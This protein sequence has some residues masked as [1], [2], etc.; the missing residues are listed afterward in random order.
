M[1]ELDRNEPHAGTNPY[2]DPG[3]AP[4]AATT[5]SPPQAA[6]PGDPINLFLHKLF[7]TS[8]LPPKAAAASSPLPAAA[9]V[10]QLLSAAA[11]SPRRAA[12]AGAHR[13]PIEFTATAGEYFRIWIV[14]LALTVL[15]LGI[16]SAWA[17]VRKKRYFYAHT[18]ID[19]DSFEY[20]GN[21][22]AILKGR[23]IAVGA[24][25]LF[26]ATGH[27]APAYQ[28]LLY[29][30]APFILPWLIV[31]S[32]AFN[33][34][35]TAYRN[36][37]LHFRGG[38]GECLGIL[39]GYGLL[40]V[41]TL[42]FAYPYFKARLVKF[43]AMYHDYGSVPF[44]IADIRNQFR[45]VYWGVI[46]R[47]LLAGVLIGFFHAALSRLPGREIATTLVTYAIYLWIFAYS[48]V[49][50]I[51]GTF[52]NLMLG[53]VDF[54]CNLRIGELFRLYLGNIVAII[55]TLGLATPWAVVRTLRY[56]A[57][58]I[59]VLGELDSFVAAESAQVSATGE[60]VGE[61]FGIDI[62]L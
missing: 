40:L 11:P 18:R 8:P 57:E 29:L 25:A 37:R 50:Y 26:Y 34:Y 58:K 42:G 2:A 36:I 59:T 5:S 15:T 44:A 12:A 4:A 39:L 45:G 38:Y 24:F 30:A 27:F 3:A 32:M 23:L 14:N 51:N 20:R 10:S 56:R 33:A 28:W 17:K 19:G 43:S 13:Y 46:G 62:S 31:K 22:I 35:N 47:G 6:A 53:P 55:A 9:A 52:N 16:Y 48:R 21:P 7:H 61:I 41:V 60:E 54:E 49:G 1:N